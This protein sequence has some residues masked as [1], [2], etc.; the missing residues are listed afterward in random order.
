MSKH[1]VLSRLETYRA[2]YQRYEDKVMEEAGVRSSPPAQV[3][4][5][6]DEYAQFLAWKAARGASAE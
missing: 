3:A 6:A 1:C 2:I 4:V 5:A